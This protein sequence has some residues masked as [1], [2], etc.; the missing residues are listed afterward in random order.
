[1]TSQFTKKA[2]QC[3]SNYF[4]KT[5]VVVSYTYN[6]FIQII[7][8]CDIRMSIIEIKNPIDWLPIPCMCVLQIDEAKPQS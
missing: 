6:S 7:M 5:I 4:E 1:M 3:L 8:I 2:K